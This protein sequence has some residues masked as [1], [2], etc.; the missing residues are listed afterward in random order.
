MTAPLAEEAA[1]LL[2]RLRERGP[3]VHCLM[4]TVV[5][6]LV[7]DGLSALG[8]VPSM[9]DAPEE[10]EAFVGKA[11]ALC[12]N[13]GTLDAARRAGIDRAVARAGEARKPWLLDPAHCDYSPARTAYAAGLLARRPAVLRANAAEFALLAMPEDVV[14]VRTGETDR[15]ALGAKAV[16]IS[17]GHPLTARVT[18][19]GCLSGALAAA[20][21]ALDAPPFAAAVAAMLA[22]GVAAQEAAT[23]A[24]GPGSFE[25]ALIDALFNLSPEDIRR[26]ARIDHDQ[27]GL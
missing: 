5:R 20:F 16:A 6:K 27:S 13:L 26:E 17:N 15:I 8:A 3:R 12:V 14:A 4:N 7:A 19:T 18:G 24:R 10:V 11:D 1:R 9:T 21:L 22:L 25:P 2:E 23:T